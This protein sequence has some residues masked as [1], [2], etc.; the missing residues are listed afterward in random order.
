MGCSKYK[1]F[2]TDYLDG[3]L[4]DTK[5]RE[6]E[7]HLVECQNCQEALNQI[8]LIISTTKG[9]EKKETSPYFVPKVMQRIKEEEIRFTTATTRLRLR[10]A[11]TFASIIV[12][13]LIGSFS[14]Y[15]LRNGIFKTERVKGPV[16][17]SH[18]FVVEQV[19]EVLGTVSKKRGKV[20][21]SYPMEVEFTRDDSMIYVLPVYS[22]ETRVMSV[23]Y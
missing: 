9:L 2:F 17:Q 7:A 5:R 15:H 19:P 6:I 12:V 21:D 10:L 14:Y 16:L 1:S 20:R 11:F 18:T 3:E 22:S 8:S 13:A 23:S 4:P